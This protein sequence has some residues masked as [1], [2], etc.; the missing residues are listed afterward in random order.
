VPHYLLQFT[1]TTQ[2]WHITYCSLAGHVTDYSSLAGFITD[3]SKAGHIIEYSKKATKFTK[4][5][6]AVH[7]ALENLAIKD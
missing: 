4:V 2:K 3:W 5:V 1:S 7:Q 6:D